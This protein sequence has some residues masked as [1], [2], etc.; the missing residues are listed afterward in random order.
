[1][2][3]GPID[4]IIRKYVAPAAKQAGLSRKGRYFRLEGRYS[5]TLLYFDTHATDPSWL[6]FEVG[7]AL[8]PLAYW[9]F[10][11]RLYQGGG[12]PTEPG[13]ES[14]FL[15]THLMPPDEWSF[16]PDER[17]PYTFKRRWA[18]GLPAGL[19]PAG[20]ALAERLTEEAFPRMHWLLDPDNA[21]AELKTP[22]FAIEQ[23][24]GSNLDRELILAIDV[25]D[26]AYVEALLNDPAR[27]QN[28]VFEASVRERFARRMA[29]E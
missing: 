14:I 22:T 7:Y 11:R 15:D 5:H 25:A 26:P 16:R 18:L 21:M 8:L 24:L 19:E 1:M 17:P 28:P 23:A 2:V 6:C 3:A 12:G 4:V 20:T 27:P 10:C 13:K 9:D 29:S